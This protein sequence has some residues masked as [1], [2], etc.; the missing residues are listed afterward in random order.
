MMFTLINMNKD[1]TITTNILKMFLEGWFKMTSIKHRNVPCLH[2]HINI[3]FQ[4][5]TCIFKTTITC[6][7]LT[8]VKKNLRKFPDSRICIFV[9]SL[10]PIQRF[11]LYLMW[12]IFNICTKCQKTTQ[13][14]IKAKFIFW[15]FND[16]DM[17][18]R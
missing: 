12:K 7:E 14:T 8:H 13:I 15:D 9:L 17:I 16:K 18:R 1:I 6:W 3:Y 11:L 4:S 10:Q 5:K 2:E